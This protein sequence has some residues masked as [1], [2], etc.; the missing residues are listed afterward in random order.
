MLA[1]PLVLGLALAPTLGGVG[2]AVAALG[3]FLLRHPLKLALADRRKGARHPRT[4]AAEG[5]A[6]LYGSLMAVGLALAAW[7]AG[8]EPLLPLLLA[9]PLVLVQLSFDARH[10][11]RR[12]LPELLGGAALGSVSSSVMLAGGWTAGQALAA[13]L[14][15]AAKAAASIL[16]VRARL[17][18]DRDQRPDPG[19]AL[20]SHLLGLAT[21]AGLAA[22]GWL[23]WLAV[24]AFAGLLA[25]AAYGLSPLH[26]AVRPQVV[27]FQE[28]AFG[29]LATGLVAAGY[30]LGV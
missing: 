15:M 7:R 5:L 9:T 24:I 11:G 29:S 25:R 13:W 28:A 19:P 16:Y 20:A 2:I 10:H 23:P 26:R 3:A 22:G 8:P 30:A 6:L 14:M 4:A 27:G 1:E 18:L 21:A 17:R 12:L